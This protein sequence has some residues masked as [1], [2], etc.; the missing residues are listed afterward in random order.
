MNLLEEDLFTFF[1]QNEIKQF[2]NL[3]QKDLVD[4]P[5]FNGSE[6]E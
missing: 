6:V 1:R 3:N 4:Q 2:N 5:I